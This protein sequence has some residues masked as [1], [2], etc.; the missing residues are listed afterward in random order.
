MPKR[1]PHSPA[2]QQPQ[3]LKLPFLYATV[4]ER[5]LKQLGAEESYAHVFEP[6]VI[7]KIRGYHK[8]TLKFTT[9]DELMKKVIK[10]VMEAFLDKTCSTARSR[11]PIAQW[12]CNQYLSHKHNGLP[13]KAE[14]LYKIG[15]NIDYFDSLKNST[16]FKE[17]K[18]SP[19]LLQYKTYAAFEAMLEPHLKRKAQ[20]E[21]LTEAFN[22][23][24][25][26][27]ENLLAETTILYDGPEGRV[28]VPHTYQASQHWGSNTKWCIS[29]RKGA[30]DMFPL[31]NKKSPIIMLLPQGQTD[32]KIALV[33]HVLYNSADDVISALP[34]PH[35][36]LM[37]RCL[38]GLS[39]G[40]R[41]G[42]APW[43]PK[44]TDKPA[45]AAD[46][47]LVEDVECE[48]DWLSWND[49]E[50]PDPTLWSNPNF[51]LTAIRKDGR[52]GNSFIYAADE[53]KKDPDFI[54]SAVGPSF[55]YAF[56]Y[57]AY[58]LQHNRDF[59]LDAIEQSEWAFEY[60]TPSLK[61]NRDFVLAAVKRNGNALEFAKEFQQDREI[62]LA[63]VNQNSYAIAY[64]ADELKQDPD[65]MM[66]L[67]EESDNF[68]FEHRT[69]NWDIW[70]PDSETLMAYQHKALERMAERGD[71]ESLLKHSR[72][73]KS[74]WGDADT[75]FAANPAATLAKIK[76]EMAA[77]PSSQSAARIGM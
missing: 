1:D 19:D 47:A 72:H 31:Y 63:A 60:A 35:N 27:K 13:V 7:K 70:R 24:P 53:L 30:D 74:T 75:L 64:V 20:R 67:F 56:K 76:A 55:G 57:A 3:H 14:D 36:S 8:G 32:N 11:P 71:R 40:A 10:P 77:K 41:Q 39:E 58:E 50:K 28:V 48:L 59:I 16:A 34:E 62:N 52:N 51:V 37:Q 15:A 42:I 61:Q 5:V 23:T 2:P 38:D 73:M 29:A 54:L 68:P 6:D 21:L 45:P 18:A 65:F 66:Q 17:T 44:K 9:Q 49:T 26:Q 33:D 25:Q 69:F 22:M 4:G 46:P 43:M 12:I